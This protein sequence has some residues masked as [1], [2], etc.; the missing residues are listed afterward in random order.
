MLVRSK[1]SQIGALKERKT[2]DGL[3]T[4]Y[5]LDTRYPGILVT[6]ILRSTT[7]YFRTGTKQSLTI[8]LYIYA[9]TLVYT[10]QCNQIVISTYF[11][12]EQRSANAYLLDLEFCSHGGNWVSSLPTPKLHVRCIQPLPRKHSLIHTS[13]R[14]RNLQPLRPLPFI[15][16]ILPITPLVPLLETRPSP[17]TCRTG[18]RGMIALSRG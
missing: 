2:S 9:I 11:L 12:V 14:I 15:L 18:G 16:L 10:V 17:N 8:T 4:I 7:G 5:L 3:L 1:I 13:P 6:W